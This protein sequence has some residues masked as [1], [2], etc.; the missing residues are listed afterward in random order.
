LRGKHRSLTEGTLVTAPT[1]PAGANRSRRTP[2]LL[3]LLALVLG[4]FGL[5][6]T[7]YGADLTAKQVKKIA[8]K[9][10]KKQAPK[11]SV[12]H[13]KTADS[14]STAGSATTA[15]TAGSAGNA[16]NLNGQPAS[17]YLDRA[18]QA[19]TTGSTAVDGSDTTQI[20]N[21]T[22]ISV[23]AGVTRV[24]VDATVGFGPVGNTNV[25][26]WIQRDGP[27]VDSG[28]DYTNGQFG[29]TSDQG[30][31]TVTR[32]FTVTPGSSPNFR[33]CVLTGAATNVDN[34][35]MVIQTVALGG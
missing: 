3:V 20:L 1:A 12:Q 34:R 24:R 22:A 32:L 28:T 31:I 2:A 35:S 30:S 9:V 11:L 14:A 27:C 5:A 10:V 15:T 26:M 19:S 8:A 21:P 29:H 18:V 7:A 25:L 23:P 16:T 33:M 17:A 13:A 4:S 6:G